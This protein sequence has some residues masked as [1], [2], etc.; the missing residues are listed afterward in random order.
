MPSAEASGSQVIPQLAA[1]RSV[2]LD[3]KLKSLLQSLIGQGQ[4]DC[5]GIVLHF[6]TTA[7][8]TLFAVCGRAHMPSCRY[9]RAPC[10]LELSQPDLISLKP[11]DKLT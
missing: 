7:S 9:A 3:D 10:Q 4:C 2:R 1:R 6:H 5:A 11:A 8:R